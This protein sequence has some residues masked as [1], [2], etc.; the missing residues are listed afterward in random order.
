MVLKETASLTCALPTL[1]LAGACYYLRAVTSR[2][3]PPIIPNGMPEDQEDEY[4]DDL[5]LTLDL[6]SEDKD[7]HPFV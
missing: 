3:T 5:D 4:S 1:T 6:I 2:P 7:C